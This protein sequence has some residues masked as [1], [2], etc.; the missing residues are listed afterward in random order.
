MLKQECEKKHKFWMIF[1]IDIFFPPKIGFWLLGLALLLLLGGATTTA[2]CALTP[3]CTISFLGLGAFSKE[4]TRALITQDR[5]DQA[6]QFVHDAID[7]FSKIQSRI[8]KE[9]KNRRVKEADARGAKSLKEPEVKALK[10]PEAK[11]SKEAEVKSVK[12]EE[13]EVKDIKEANNSPKQN[14]VK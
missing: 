9:V 8:A 4:Q 3:I 11:T 6:T 7:K 13:K 10:E 14:S 2:V 12:E 5:L 1:F